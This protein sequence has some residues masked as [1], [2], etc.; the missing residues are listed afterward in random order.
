M[1]SRRLSVASAVIASLAFAAPAMAQ[2]NT[3]YNSD[4][5]FK[6]FGLDAA[7]GGTTGNAVVVDPA[8]GAWANTSP[9]SEWVGV[10][11]SGSLPGGSGDNVA[12][13]S[14]QFSTSFLGA[15]SPLSMT[16]WTDNYFF[17]YTFNGVHYN[18]TPAPAPGEFA[19]PAPSTFAI[20]PI[21]GGQ[22]ALTLYFDGDGQTDAINVAFTATP[23]PASLAL[24]A[25][26]LLGLGGVAV[27]RRRTQG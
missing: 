2:S 1:I 18:V 25:T 24:L 23:E 4:W 17:G 26:G 11:S 19:L 16:V 9:N 27:R 3:G 8:P 13:V 20:S 10:N 12:K 15:G 6:Y 22:N 7:V 14:Y 21:S 5:T